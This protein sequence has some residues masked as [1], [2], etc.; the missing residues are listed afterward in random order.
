MIEKPKRV[1]PRTG[2]SL[3]HHWW[4][5]D[6]AHAAEKCEAALSWETIRRTRSYRA[7]W[8]KFKKETLLIL[9]QQGKPT[10]AGAFQHMHFFQRARQA[11]GQPHFDLLMKGFDPDLT[12]LELEP[13]QRLTARGFIVAGGAALKVNPEYLLPRQV[14]EKR[15]RLSMGM[16]EL[17]RNGLGHLTLA[18]KM[19]DG[20]ALEK[21][22]HTDFFRKL[23][24][25]TPGHYVLIFFDTRGARDAL[26]DAFD[27]EMLRWLGTK[28]PLQGGEMDA[29]YWAK[30]AM[31]TERLAIRWNPEDRTPV[32][33]WTPE[34]RDANVRV[35]PTELVVI[36]SEDP[37][38]AILVVSARHNPATVRAAFHT[39]LKA[40]QFKK[41]HPRCIK[42]WK[43][44]TIESHQ[45]PRNPDGTKR[46]EL[47]ERGHPIRQKV[48]HHLF[49]PERDLPSAKKP[50]RS[51]RRRNPWL[52]L[53]ANDVA[54]AGLPLGK[55]TIEG[56][57]LL[58]RSPSYD[59][60]HNAQR[61]AARRLKEL[62][63]TVGRLDKNLAHWNDQSAKLQKMGFFKAAAGES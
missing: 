29:S 17:G 19:C 38:F 41:W 53:A 13:T 11:L 51:A 25:P 8:R 52:G 9:Q 48:V 56:A 47:D 61:S 24:L 3:I 30:V 23:R 62:D 12:W 32:E 43:A 20:F 1:H 63:D 59:A 5:F 36:P 2:D 40:G 55:G 34:I 28:P 15:P 7:L 31:A 16:V 6:S 10:L 39:Q 18:K 35:K 26:L 58:G 57:F 27:I 4:W 54:T 33:F 49:D 42:F 50:T 60:L 37:A 44:L 21:V 14:A 45:F 22:A 46:I